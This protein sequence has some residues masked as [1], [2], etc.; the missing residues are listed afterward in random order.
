MSGMGPIFLLPPQCPVTRAI[1]SALWVSLSLT[2]RVKRQLSME[3]W[4]SAFPTWPIFRFP[5]FLPRFP[6][7]QHGLRDFFSVWVWRLGTCLAFVTLSVFLVG[8]PP[9][10]VTLAISLQVPGRDNSASVGFSGL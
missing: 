9:N 6:H 5:S 4:A 3:V 7:L 10:D 1:A 2:S 8:M